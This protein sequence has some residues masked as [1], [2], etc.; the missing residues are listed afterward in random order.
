MRRSFAP[1]KYSQTTL[2]KSFSYKRNL[3][4]INERKNTKRQKIDIDVDNDDKND[5]DYEDNS[6]KENQISK[7]PLV[8]SKVNSKINQYKQ[9]LKLKN[10]NITNR[11]TKPFILPTFLNGKRP[12][13][14]INH[15]QR[16]TLGPRRRISF[17]AKPL[18]DPEDESAIILFEPKE[19]TETEKLKSLSKNS[20]KKDENLKIQVHVIVDPVIGKVLRPHQVEG[21]RFLY[22]CTTGKCVENAYGAIMA[23][24]MGLGKTL[25]CIT[26]LWTLLC[27]SPTPGKPEINKAIIVCPSS[28]VRNW[29]KEL[30]HWIG[31]DRINLLVCDGSLGTKDETLKILSSFASAKGRSIT[32]VLIISYE[33][34]RT[35]IEALHNTDTIGLMLCDEGHRLKNQDSQT[36]KALNEINTKRRVILTGTPIQNDLTEYFSLINFANP[37]LLGTSQEFRRKYEIPILRG[38]DSESTDKEKELGE[39]RL[40]ELLEITNKFTIRRTSDLLSKYLPLK[41]DYV[42]F[43][44]LSDYQIEIYKEFVKSDTIKKL[45]SGKNAQTLKAITTLKKLCNH[46]SLI[47]LDEYNIKVKKPERITTTVNNSSRRRSHKENDPR[48]EDSGKLALLDNMISMIRHTSDDKIVL[49]S[50]YTK[51]LELFEL[52]CRVRNYQCVRLDGSMTPKKKMKIVEEFNKPDSPCFIFLLS[53]KAGGCGLNLIGA[54]RL[55]LFDPDWNPANDM[56][57]LARIWREGQQKICYIYRLI[58]T[59][60]VE[61]KIFQ[62]QAHKQSISSCV[63][64]EDEDVE[65]HFSRNDLKKLFEFNE[66]TLSDTHDTFKCNRCVRGRQ[67]FKP[68]EVKGANQGDTSFWNHYSELELHK[69]PDKILR[70]CGKGII[71]YAFQTKSQE[72]VSK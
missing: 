45:I 24:E 53:S 65:R 70:E 43:C 20:L 37:G 23:D 19:L 63:V 1:S 22:N 46:P 4:V 8:V 36:Y 26:L 16:L 44:R 14:I 32:P 66:H 11:L 29:M 9:P 6:D 60:T 52:L 3:N 48:P 50:N 27:Q 5:S 31:K 69:I 49:I 15:S 17:I 59:G 28:L 57:A 64:D 21:V 12:P 2:L 72:Q 18:Y 40:K 34:L 67:V 33:S 30:L 41:Y 58:A 62:R 39:E 25:Q 10:S 7:K 47:D 38:R 61:E 51:T 35:Y 13:S 56:Q 68:P 42:V 55:I 71:T 54:N